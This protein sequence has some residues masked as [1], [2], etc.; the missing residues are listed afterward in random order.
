MQIKSSYIPD[1][2]DPNGIIMVDDYH[3]GYW[4]QY[5]LGMQV[6]TGNLTELKTKYPNKKIYGISLTKTQASTPK[7]SSQY[8]WNPL[9]PY[10]FP[11]GGVDLISNLRSNGFQVGN[12]TIN[13]INS[14]SNL[15]NKNLTHN[16]SNDPLS[17]PNGTD[18]TNISNQMPPGFGNTTGING[19][20]GDLN[21]VE[22][23]NSGTLIFNGGMVK[24]YE[25]S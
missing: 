22:M 23:F 21:S 4:V 18:P 9:L 11:F 10:S 1:K 20:R 13:N 25:L 17:L 12:G 14:A 15:T 7:F 3:T 2:T 19:G 16:A 24:I 6:E 8:L 5:V